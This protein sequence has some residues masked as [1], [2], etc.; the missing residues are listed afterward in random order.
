MAKPRK[1]TTRRPVKNSRVQEAQKAASERR[2]E[3]DS[4]RGQTGAERARISE[5]NKSDAD[6]RK[7]LAAQAAVDPRAKRPPISTQYEKPMAK[8]P[9]S[10]GQQIAGLALSFGLPSQKAA[11]AALADPSL[12][13]VNPANR[14]ARLDQLRNAAD[15]TRTAQLKQKQQAVYMGPGQ[16]TQFNQ[17]N[18]IDPETGKRTTTTPA[19]DDIQSY[20]DL[21]GWLSDP[22]KVEQIRAAAF[23]VGLKPVAYEDI[24]KLW[25]SVVKQAADSFSKTG[26]R[27]TPWALLALRGKYAG[28]DGQMQDKITTSTQVDEVDPATARGMITQTAQNML[29]RDPTKAEVDDFIAKAQMIAKNNPTITTT[30]MKTGFDGAAEVGTSQTTTKG[31]GQAVNDQSQMAA[32]DMAQQS[33]DYGAYQAAGT[34]FPLLFQALN[35]P[36]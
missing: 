29:G 15:Q 11:L 21:M 2:I 18:K 34:Y 33:D 36:V 8:G 5:S 1:K 7:L 22:A 32:K 6:N 12:Y 3:A 20:D 24:A 35:S 13:G 23:K 27:V 4:L 31:G 19:G 25:Q 14:Q 17:G 9:S 16:I 10:Q 28:P 26:Q 30:R